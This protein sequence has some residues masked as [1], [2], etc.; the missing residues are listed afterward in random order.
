MKGFQ[1][2]TRVSPE[3]TTKDPEIVLD[4]YKYSVI[5]YL[6]TRDYWSPRQ[7]KA[8]SC[9]ALGEQGKPPG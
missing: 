6:C 4:K 3:I 7:K 9:L 1:D 8:F 5:M 2:F